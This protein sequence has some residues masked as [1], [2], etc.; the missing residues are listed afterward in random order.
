MLPGPTMAAVGFPPVG[1]CCR[2]GVVVVIGASLSAGRSG[3]A[4]ADEALS[5]SPRDGW[6]AGCC[7]LPTGGAI[8]KPCVPV[9]GTLSTR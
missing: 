4:L 1:H 3:P 5:R 8:I 7:T 9:N 2:V 6:R